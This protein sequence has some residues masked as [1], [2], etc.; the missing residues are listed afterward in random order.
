[1]TCM[2]VD[3][4]LVRENMKERMGEGLK[5]AQTD[6]QNQRW[7]IQYTQ[8]LNPHV[9]QMIQVDMGRQLTGAWVS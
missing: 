1:M 7:Y 3:L 4:S 9:H 2:C 6:I 8:S 5:T